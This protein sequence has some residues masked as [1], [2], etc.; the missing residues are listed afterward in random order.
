MI[1]KEKM[2]FILTQQSSCA[3]PCF[4]MTEVKIKRVKGKEFLRL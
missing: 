3:N 1:S 4:K 2:S